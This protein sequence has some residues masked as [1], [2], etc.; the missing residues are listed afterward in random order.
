LPSARS[1]HSLNINNGII[2]LF[3]GSLEITKEANDTRCYNIKD[4]TWYVLF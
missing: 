3:G 2:Y 1:G 4:N